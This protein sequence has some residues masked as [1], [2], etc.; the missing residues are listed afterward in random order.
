MSTPAKVPRAVRFALVQFN[1]LPPDH[2]PDAPHQ[3]L[4]RAHEFVRKAA[5]KGANVVVFPEYFISGI[6]SDEKHW[7][8]AQREHDPSHVQSQEETTS[9]LQSF[10]KLAVKHDIDIVAGTI[11]EKAAKQVDGKDVLSNVAHY[12]TRKGEVVGRYK[13]ANLWWPEKDYLTRGD[14]GHQVFDTEWGKTGLLVCKHLQG[15]SKIFQ[16]LTT[17]HVLKTGWDAA[18]PEAFRS[19]ILQKCEI[20]IIPTFWTSADGDEI[21][22]AHNP[23]CEELYLDNLIVTRAFENEVSVAT[24]AFCDRGK[25]RADFYN[26]FRC[27]VFVNAGGSSKDGFIGRSGVTLPFLGK[28][29]GT[30]SNEEEMLIVDVDLNILDVCLLIGARASYP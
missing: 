24:S 7:G 28:V 11:V 25:L 26:T 23:Q 27:V 9:W 21:G 6:V 22:L 1:P 19:L 4:I 12:I 29:G 5:E 16:S 15:L 20:V 8:L 14:E 18:W 10:C 3:N 17:S 30:K 2:A 13:K